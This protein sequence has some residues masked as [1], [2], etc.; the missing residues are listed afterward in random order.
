MKIYS[1]TEWGARH[2]AGIA[3]APMPA[4]RVW[5]HHTAGRSGAATSTVEQDCQ[6]V[7]D[8]EQI[9]QNR[10]GHGISYSF[11][12]TRSGRIFEGTG[13]GRVGSHTRGD[14]TAS[15][16]IVLTGN[17]QNIEPNAAQ[18]DALT[19]L[20]ANGASEGWWAAPQLAG[21]HQDAPGAATAC[22]GRH[23][24]SRIAEVNQRA[25]GQLSAS[26]GMPLVAYSTATLEQAQTWA[27]SKNAHPRFV[28]D[29]L[30]ALYAAG[31]EQWRANGGRS[32]N[33]A[34]V[35]A[36]AAKETGWGH[37]RGVLNPTFH[38][39]A[40]I[41]T[42]PG[43]GDFD[44]DAH[45]RFPSWAE[46]ARAHWNHLAAYT[47]LTVVGEPHPRYHTVARLAWAGTITTVDQLGARWAP[48]S[49]YGTDIVRMV[50]ELST[51]ASNSGK[52]SADTSKLPTQGG[53]PAATP[54]AATSSSPRPVLRR[55]ARS[56]QV[57]VLQ[58]ALGI[59]ADGV[60]GPH[61]ERAVRIFQQTHGLTV[62]GIVGPR[63]WAAL[64]KPQPA[65][66]TLRRGS[67]GPDV[68]HLQRQ[69]GSRNPAFR[70]RNGIFGP[71][72]EAEV[73][74]HQRRSRITVDGI[75]GP[76]TWRTLR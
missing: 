3:A 57:A 24:A 6:L 10:F 47:G 58:S 4:Q 70:W 18:I 37:F 67:R 73:K 7:R 21:G 16:A 64:D 19:W 9:G 68:V 45:Q 30:P 29:I 49:S 69:L 55:G 71:Q 20:V 72:T 31:M 63:T 33:P 35:A 48:S 62:D 12:I 60:F 43:G 27:R 22:P 65:R 1:R 76:Q 54:Q 23:L 32:I 66:P 61:T 40:G 51:V 13:P 50:N 52:A 46:G 28:D 42:G 14:N 34:V 15:G 17:Y 56:P 38:N 44:P 2:I 74:A 59:T 41:K 5:L 26:D 36:Q 11:V 25:T 53:E 39:T 8:L 75:V